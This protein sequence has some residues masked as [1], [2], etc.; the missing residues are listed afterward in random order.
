M[1]KPLRILFVDDNPSD[2]ILAIRE[3][4]KE[5]QDLLVNQI[6]DEKNLIQALESGNFDLVIT[7]YQIRWTDGLKVLSAVKTHRPECPVIMFT[8]T[9][10]EEIAVEAMKGGLDDY[11]IKT[12]KHFKRLPA[13]VRLALERT[14]QHK[15]ITEA[16]ERYHEL[17]ESS[18]DGIASADLKGNILNCNQAFADMLGYNKN[19]IYTLTFKDYVS[20]KWHD[21]VARTIS[22]Q[23]LSRGYSDELE[24]EGVK[25]DG[26]FI[27]V[28][29]RVWLIKDKEGKPTEVWAIARNITKRK[30]AEEKLK[31]YA[32]NLEKMVE[33]RTAELRESEERYRGLYESSTD[34]IMSVNLKGDLVE[35]NQ[36]FADMLGYTKEE[37]IK[38][39]LQD[40]AP[41]EWHGMGTRT[42]YKQIIPRGYLDETESDYIKKDGT[43]IPV[44]SR[45]WI[46][47]DEDGNPTGVWGIVRDIT[48]RKKLDRLKSKFI[49]TAAHE[50][51]TPLSA[52][53]AHVD[54]L[55]L[56]SK[57]IDLP[58]DI[59]RRIGIISRNA[60]RLAVL[61]NNLLDYTRLE[62]GTVKP[63]M[64]LD[65]L[66]SVVIQVVKEVM[67]LA[68]KHKHVLDL[69][70]VAMLPYTYMDREMIHRVFSNLLSNAI[71]Y[72]PDGGKINVFIVEENGKLHITINDTGIGV[73]E[74]DLENIFLPFNV[75]D[76]SESEITTSL[77]EF[78]RTGLGLAITKEYVKMHDGEVWAESRFG[79]GSSFHVILP[80]KSSSPK[81]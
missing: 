63:K 53:K 26:T 80:I 73:A 68:H 3:L 25:K 49:N 24:I 69:N 59:N 60:S 57:T 62:E 2:R 12:P 67:P 56:K 13:A 11:I 44:S 36:A 22:E 7:D 17:F 18:I 48:E 27:S 47:K 72:T 37:L 76:L 19:E 58:E 46:I 40:I 28:A 42:F 39:S 8:G 5:F 30:K 29:T 45:G 16:E 71:K 23:V 77:S 52:L 20:S 79:E 66:E 34:G 61:I 70:T 38:L 6:I 41:S 81:H 4:E 35:C 31:E 43:I 51:R 65:S 55:E 1:N 10:N 50:L 14:Q 78:E 74:K 33:A 21:L 15:A 64:E 32:E 75:V 9:G 54:L